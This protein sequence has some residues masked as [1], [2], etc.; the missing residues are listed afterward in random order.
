MIEI[1]KFVTL[2]IKSEVV[3]N[4]VRKVTEKAKKKRY[5]SCQLAS[6]PPLTVCYIHMLQSLEKVKFI[7]TCWDGLYS[8]NNII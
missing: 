2:L 3:T 6:H 7:F 1:H 4:G 5:V 8:P